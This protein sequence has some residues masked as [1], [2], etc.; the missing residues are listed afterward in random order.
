MRNNDREECIAFVYK[1]RMRIWRV[2]WNDKGK[3]LEVYS[4]EDYIMERN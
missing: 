4:T 2:L 1:L 3:N